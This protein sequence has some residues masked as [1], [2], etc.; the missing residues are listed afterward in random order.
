MLELANMKQI[1][2]P[3]VDE[4]ERATI[5]G[6]NTF[7]DLISYLKS[8]E[9]ALSSVSDDDIYKYIMVKFYKQITNTD[10]LTYK[11]W[12]YADYQAYLADV[13]NNN[14]AEVESIIDNLRFFSFYIFGENSST[15][16]INY[17]NSILALQSVDST[18]S[19]E[20]LANEIHLD[21]V[22]IETGSSEIFPNSFTALKF[23]VSNNDSE[24]LSNYNLG[25]DADGSKYLE[26]KMIYILPQVFHAEKS[27][28]ILYSYYDN[29]L[30][31]IN[32]DWSYGKESITFDNEKYYKIAE[33]LYMSATLTTSNI[34]DPDV[35]I[36]YTAYDKHNVL[37]YTNVSVIYQ[38]SADTIYDYTSY[39]KVLSG[40]DDVFTIM[41]IKNIAEITVTAQYLTENSGSMR[42]S[43]IE[44]SMIEN[45]LR[46]TKVSYYTGSD[47]AGQNDESKWSVMSDDNYIKEGTYR[48]S[49][50]GVLLFEVRKNNANT[51]SILLSPVVKKISVVTTANTIGNYV[52]LFKWAR[53]MTYNIDGTMENN[54]SYDIYTNDITFVEDSKTE[55]SLYAVYTD[56]VYVSYNLGFPEG[57]H[58]TS[59]KQ[60]ILKLGESTVDNL[61]MPYEAGFTLAELKA[62]DTTSSGVNYTIDYTELFDESTGRFV[63]VSSTA[64]HTQV[65]LRAY[66]NIDDIAYTQMRSSIRRPAGNFNTLLANEVVKITNLNENLFDYEYSWSLNDVV[67]FETGTLRF[68]KGGVSSESG[69]YK[70]KVVAKIKDAYKDVVTESGS[71]KS[72]EVSVDCTF[73]ASK[74]MNVSLGGVNTAI[75]NAQSHM[76]DWRLI[77]QYSYYDESLDAYSNDTAN[78]SVFYNTTGSLSATVKQG[79][80]EV[81]SMI[82]VGT[83]SIK[84][85]NETDYYVLNSPSV[86][87]EFEF[88][89]TPFVLDIAQFNTD[90]SKLFDATEDELVETVYSG[91]E[92]VDILF[93]RDSGEDI[94]TY[95]MYVHDIVSENR[96]NYILKYN[97]AVVFEDLVADDTV[98]V[99]EFTITTAGILKLY[100]QTTSSVSEIIDEVYDEDGY[101]ISMTNNFVL[102]ISQG[103]NILHQLT[104]V[105]YDVENEKIVSDNEIINLLR[106]QISDL[107][108]YFNNGANLTTAVDGGSY[109][110]NFV[111]GE[112]ITKYFTT[113]TFENGYHFV[114]GK[115]T[116]NINLLSLNKTFDGSAV[117]Y[118]D[119]DLNILPAVDSET[120]VY[121]KAQY[122]SYYASSSVKVN[123]SIG[124]SNVTRVSNYQLSATSTTA[125]ISKLDATATLTMTESSY[126]YGTIKT[127]NFESFINPF[128]L[129]ANGQ[130][131]TRLM[132]QGR[133]SLSYALSASSNENGVVYA[134]EYSVTVTASFDDFNVTITQ[135]T[136]T[137]TK[138]QVYPTL[139]EGQFR[140]VI[141]YATVGPHTQTFNVAASGDVLTLDF[142]ADV[143]SA[144][145]FVAEY[146]YDVVL[147]QT[148]Y[149]NNS[150]EVIVESGNRA[151]EILADTDIIYLKLSDETVLTKEYNGN[152]FDLAVDLAGLKLRVTN[153]E[154]TYTSNITFWKDDAQI[155][156]SDLTQLSIYNAKT[157]D[158]ESQ[159]I[160]SFETVGSYSLT[161]KTRSTTYPSILFES[162]KYFTITKRTVDATALTISKEYNGTNTLEIDSFAEKVPEDDVLVIATYAD[163]SVGTGKSVTLALAGDDSANY[164]LSANSVSGEISKKSARVIISQAEYVY[165]QFSKHDNIFF[166]VKD[167][168]DVI[169]SSEYNISFDVIADPSKYVGTWEYLSCG[170]YT[171]EMSG[172]ADNYNLTF[173][174]TQKLSIVQYAI[175]IVFETSGKYV[176]EYGEAESKTNTFTYVYRTPL[177]ED[178]T[179]QVTRENGVEIGF[180]KALSATTTN[181]NYRINSTTD[182]SSGVFR[183]IKSTK[184]VYILLTNAETISSSVRE[185][186]SMEFDG[187]D[188][189][190]ILFENNSGNY[191]LQF[192]DGINTKSFNLYTYMLNGSTYT[193]QIVT[194]QNVTASFR[195]LDYT[196]VRN[197]GTYAFYVE[198]ASATNYEIA[199]RTEGQVYA[200]LVIGK[201]EI[202]FK[203]AVLTKV[204]NNDDATLSYEDARD[205][206]DGLA[207]GDEVGISLSFMKESNVAKYVGI[208]Y[209]IVAEL[210][211]EELT[212]DNYILMTTTSDGTIVTGQIT[213][214]DLT[215]YIM[216]KSYVYGAAVDTSELYAYTTDVDLTGY[217]TTRMS[218]SLSLNAPAYSTSGKLKVGE[219]YLLC[220]CTMQDFNVTY[221]VNGREYETYGENAKVTITSK[222]TDY[223]AVSGTLQ[224]LFTKVYD[225]TTDCTTA[226]GGSSLLLLGDVYDGDVVSIAGATY[227]SADVGETIEVRLVLGG[228]DAGNYY[229]ENWSYGK[230]VPIMVS[231]RFDYNAN[232]SSSVY[233]NNEISGIKT[234][235]KLAFPF[236]SQ[237]YLTANSYESDT[238]Y[239][240]NFPTSLSGYT[241]FTFAVWTLRFENVSSGTIKYNY[242]LDLVDELKME[243]EYQDQT[244]AIHVGN[245]PN[246]VILLNKLMKEDTENVCGMYYKET[247]TPI[248]TFTAAWNPV[249]YVVQVRVADENGRTAEYGSVDVDGTV[250]TRIGQVSYGYGDVVT[251]VATPAQH[252]RYYGSYNADDGTRYDT[253]PAEYIELSRSGNITTLTITQMTTSY[254]FVVRFIP[255]SITTEIDTT[256]A[257]GTISTRTDVVEETNKLT[258]TTNYFNLDDITLADLCL[259]RPGYEI[260]SLSDGTNTYQQADF[261]AVY[262]KDLVDEIGELYANTTLSL[263]PEFESVGVPVTLDYGFDNIKNII[264]VNFDSKYNTSP[265]WV[266]TPERTG[267]IFGGWFTDGGERI[268]GETDMLLT[269]EHTL[270]ADWTIASFN[271]SLTAENLTMRI[272]GEVV[273]EF[274]QEVD[275][276]TTL[277]IVLEADD[278]YALPSSLP[279][280]FA[281][282]VNGNL[283]NVT[284]TMPGNDLDY[285]F[286]AVA[287]ANT[288]ETTGQ[289]IESVVAFDI[290]DGTEN[291]IAVSENVFTI[292]T[293]KNVKVVVT[294]EEG[295]IIDSYALSEEDLVVDETNENGVLTLVI[296]GIKS[297]VSLSVVAIQGKH[298]INLVFDDESKIETFMLT[299][300][301]SY[302]RYFE[303]DSFEVLLGEN[304]EFNLKYVHGYKLM[305]CTTESGYTIDTTEREIG[306]E[307]YTVV[308]VSNIESDG[309]I[310]LT[311]ELQKYTLSLEVVSY[312]ENKNIVT[313]DAN[314][315]I[316]RENGTRTFVGSYGRELTLLATTT[317][318]IYSFAGWS[319]DGI[320]IFE[321]ES[322][323]VYAIDDD[324]TIFAIFSAI[325]FDITFGTLEYYTLYGE[326]SDATKLERHYEEISGLGEGYYED[327]DMTLQVSG[328]SIY[329]GSSR[330][331][332]YKTPAGYG[333]YGFGYKEGND[334]VYISRDDNGTNM[335][336]ISTLD[337]DE[338]NTTVKIYIVVQALTSKIELNTFVDIGGDEEENV[339]VGS[340]KLVD[341]DGN[342]VN[343]YGY[344]DGTRVHY[345]PSSFTGID[346]VSKKHFDIIASTGE[347]VYLKITIYR[348]GYRL[349]NIV[350][351]NDNV[352]IDLVSENNGTYIYKVSRFTGGENLEVKVL[353]RPNLNKILVDFVSGTKSVDG[354]AFSYTAE[355]PRKVF[356]SGKGYS[357]IEV[358]AYTD[359]SFVVYAYVHM[360]FDVD[361][362]DIQIVD[363]SGIVDLTTVTYQTM[364]AITTGYSALVTFKVEDYLGEN[365]ISLKIIPKTYTVKFI[366]EG[367]TLVTIKNVQYGSFIDLA[368]TNASNI[369]ISSEK[370]MFAGGRLNLKLGKQG[371]TFEGFFSYENGAG[372]RYINSEGFV[373]LAW[374]ETGYYY[375]LATATYKTSTN[376]TIDADTGEITV[377]LFLYWSYLKTRITFTITPSDAT[378]ATAQDMITGI[379][380]TNSW[381]YKSAPYYIEVAFNTTIKINAPEIE[382]YT[383]YKFIVEEKDKQGNW[384]PQA[385]SYS[386]S[387]PWE[388]NELD[389]VVECNIQIIYFAQVD[390]VIY[391]GEGTYAVEQDIDDAQAQKLIQDGYVDTRQP[392][393]LV[394][395]PDDGYIF[396]RWNNITAGRSSASEEWEGLTISSKTTFIMNLQGDYVTLRF[397]DIGAS[398]TETP[399]DTTFGRIIRAT[400][401]SI[402]NTTKKNYV[403]GSYNR[404]VFKIV[405][406]EIEVKVGDIVTFAVEIDYGFAAIWNISEMSYTG[407]S[408]GY[409]M[410][411]L[412]ITADMCVDDF[413]R[414]LPSFKNEILSIYVKR[415]FVEEQKGLGAID[416]DNVDLAGSVSFGGRK[417]DRITAQRGLDVLI[418]VR[419]NDRYEV[420][421]LYVVAGAHEIDLTQYYARGVVTLLHETIEERG[422][423]GTLQLVVKFGR[424]LWEEENI[425]TSIEGEGTSRNPYEISTV[426]ELTFFMQ[427]INSGAKNIY[428]KYYYNA[429]YVLMNNLDLG[430]EFWT[431]IGTMQH[432][433]NGYFNFNNKEIKA[434][435]N[436]FVYE[437]ISYNGLFGVL[438][439]KA[440]IE[441]GQAATWYWYLIGVAVLALITTVIVLILVARKNKARREQM[442]RK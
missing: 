360:G 400:A 166:E 225:G 376:A 422:I 362:N 31:S 35:D 33:K 410:F 245:N 165:G 365:N 116:I 214:A 299:N 100:Y 356:S 381:F 258:W 190:S 236:V 291:P 222:K 284:L 123:L 121:I 242:L 148:Y 302:D 429:N 273:D 14:V 83:Y 379:D 285:T 363:E 385:E 431:P 300:G 319:K 155:T 347:T 419:P 192:T 138:L 251:I 219:Y 382:G 312:D 391:G 202:Y 85:N 268:Y 66:W 217:D 71:S 345:S 8:N 386:S 316:I 361:E 308:S 281:S 396:T 95:N 314:S 315:A 434:I 311:T 246:T 297:D 414:V 194:L 18:V 179:I 169:S 188:Y 371:Y 265:D 354:G 89:M 108:I 421:E 207:I 45:L 377:S 189:S 390:V 24:V 375:D 142:Y 411:E 25:I 77:V 113:I 216:S 39:F 48:A 120:E 91:F 266:E 21:K 153:G 101:T 69:T 163:A 131:V 206:I 23:Y 289:H 231:L 406:N 187:N 102:Q 259:Q 209:S 394:A 274:A 52:K 293:G 344:V 387:I 393:T 238:I 157:V 150:I 139:T 388:T 433:F 178:L 170:S 286:R 175:D 223:T 233:S 4:Q 255:Q 126:V 412:A 1:M 196:S 288:F 97:S 40:E 132:E 68:E 243:Y 442:E 173:D 366:E 51:I 191:S 162:M 383:F 264:T 370:I 143:S 124:G 256:N 105:L 205:V 167:G 240:Q 398:G 198:N 270:T 278:G 313:E 50:G 70:L 416:A 296:S 239:L 287:N 368:Q 261:G 76:Q 82:N 193:R 87:T 260:V 32:I 309:E 397:T 282:V 230:I 249:E 88:T 307:I 215:L 350:S 43:T 428:G 109:V 152:A 367:T 277:L 64:P 262:I 172:S 160:T 147:N 140:Q 272:D 389:S 250:I 185:S 210:S 59:V 36:E 399:Y 29:R 341:K 182:S 228:S 186:V 248:V 154:T 224:D 279:E 72:I 402:N 322:T 295:Y 133:Y 424:L 430:K 203:D 204:F 436:P 164:Q 144:S 58:T 74:I 19:V 49:E 378:G 94:G 329:Y 146:F 151:I 118:F 351:D 106:A 418:G 110:Y 34:G 234:I 79:L 440:V 11:N 27:E 348:V 104:L 211:G 353:F 208:N 22:V 357:T 343:E 327:A 57:Y 317:N 28:E 405:L 247:D 276:G 20:N 90:L 46:F 30:V 213:K 195:F 112:N 235:T 330:D 38:E 127:T 326:Y 41:N 232:G 119:T 56:L 403:I 358:S 337:L 267:Y 252:A 129:M 271:L 149:A 135:P 292:E 395:L 218:I 342:N 254:N 324:E 53:E 417:T 380:Y 369:T 55:I 12:T 176:V 10:Y 128:T 401:V 201:K 333:F 325:K 86:Q 15:R 407:Y 318:Q 115:Q 145:E 184:V 47:T 427:K 63:G 244:F 408:D 355:D 78:V 183:I 5:N 117:R 257:Q 352:T 13:E 75:Y 54:G 392:F 373:T 298:T 7:E 103:S 199:F 61:Y 200:D 73:F 221:N 321:T 220:N 349:Y 384:R 229:V 372:V 111:A 253:T 328:V 9:S 335:I 159:E 409:Y 413:V 158:G 331:V 426:E 425:T 283:L 338:N 339:N 404:D 81:S 438:G 269:E 65:K 212:L 67:L 92:D 336:N 432:A 168:D 171:L 226:D 42:L 423:I 44:D 275:F 334:F 141:T 16:T 134:G 301:S 303:F 227:A 306:S 340:V 3:L 263:S 346:T 237:S 310:N 37:Y 136:F 374:A 441:G 137:I 290:T 304:L 125:Q 156:I 197:V 2:M 60:S 180:Y 80:E 437:Y 332:Y 122:E 364:D 181:T 96:N 6:K 241:G 84:L 26:I 420:V 359:S 62:Q 93:V 415:D 17:Y 439:E 99:G 294:A 174:N 323:F 280:M 305:S 107:S 130:N 320:N 114:I 177:F 98:V 161:L 435:Y